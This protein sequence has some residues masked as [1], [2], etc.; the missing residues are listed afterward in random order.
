MFFL[1]AFIVLIFP[2]FLYRYEQSRFVKFFGPV[3]LCY[4]LGILLGNMNLQQASIVAKSLSELSIPLAIPLLLL[5]T[6]FIAWFKSSK[7]TLISFILIVFT[8]GFSCTLANFIFDLPQI[9]KISAMMAG[10]FTGGMANLNSIGLAIGASHESFVLLNL[11]DVICGGAYL[12]FIFTIGKRIFEYILP[13]YQFKGV[14]E[15]QKESLFSSLA[16][17][18]KLQRILFFIA[19]SILVLAVCFT[20]SFF[21]FAKLNVVFLILGISTLAICLSFVE[22]L[23]LLPGSYEVG[24]YLLYV[25][26]ISI[27]MM[28]NLSRLADA[29]FEYLYFCS[30]I[31]LLSASLHLVLC[32]LFKIDAHTALITSAAAIFG[33][34]FVAPVAKSIN[35]KEVI[36]AGVTTGVIGYAVGNYLGIGLYYLFSSLSSS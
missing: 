7:A 3:V 11:S 16:Y 4:V 18:I 35:N 15:Q 36:V 5:S 30:F 23:R 20:L 26:C 13:R 25:F 1:L 19:L 22:K 33:P 32:R 17:K 10:V 28:V 9:N 34:P 29:N 24:E 21:I 6:N 31:L 8:V 12:F 2:Y 14:V 27:G